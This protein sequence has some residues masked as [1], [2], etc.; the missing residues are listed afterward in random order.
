MASHLHKVV[1]IFRT[2]EIELKM[3]FR[4]SVLGFLVVVVAVW[5]QFDLGVTDTPNN[6]PTMYR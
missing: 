2:F 5:L 4:K 1:I 6:Q 3:S